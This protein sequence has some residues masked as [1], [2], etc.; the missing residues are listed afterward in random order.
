MAPI[1]TG[2]LATPADSA[3]VS[4]GAAGTAALQDNRWYM[5]GRLLGPKSRF[6]GFKGTI[7]SI[8]RIKSGLSV[9]DAG[10][11]FMF[12]FNHEANRNRALHEGPWFYR[13]TM[14]L[15]GEYDGVGLVE[16]WVA[17]K[18]LPVALR[19]KNALNLIGYVV[20]QVIKFD[21][22]AL[23]RREE[24]QRI[25]LVLDTRRRVRTW[26][27][28]EFSSLVQPEINLIYEKVKGFCRDCGFFEHDARDAMDFW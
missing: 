20:G 4:L 16:I 24:E 14:L 2:A 25:R 10:D 22:S 3:K 6:P 17:V 11:R 21:Q 27:L 18:G 1:T 28:F 23:R 5:V 26:M 12:Q 15:V 8:W 7:S 19:N 9:H 13:N